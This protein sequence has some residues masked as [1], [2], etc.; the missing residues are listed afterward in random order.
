MTAKTRKRTMVYR[1]EDTKQL[2]EGIL[3]D[4]AS[5]NHSS[6]SFE[7]ESVVLEYLLTNNRLVNRWLECLYSPEFKIGDVFGM[8]F[9]YNSIGT[10][11]K[12]SHLPL[13][14]LVNYIYQLNSINGINECDVTELTNILYELDNL[15]SFCETKL[16]ENPSLEKEYST[17]SMSLNMIENDLKNEK[18]VIRPRDFYLLVIKYWDCL[19]ESTYT[20]RLLSY[21]C[22]LHK[23]LEITPDLRYELVT[24]LRDLAKN[25]NEDL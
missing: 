23:D 13:L 4:K 9:E 16:K 17:I 14:D 21:Y 24:L 15:K 6:Y 18:P 3:G 10:C 1:D 8:I 20:F 5:I 7:M 11:G 19:E 12:S 22:L 2:L 25:W